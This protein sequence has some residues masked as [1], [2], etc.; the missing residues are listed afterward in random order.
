[1]PPINVLNFLISN[2]WFR[3]SSLSQVS[4]RCRLP[5]WDQTRNFKRY[6][7]ISLVP[8]EIIMVIIPIFFPC[9]KEFHD[10]LQ[11]LCK[12]EATRSGSPTPL[13][14]DFVTTSTPEQGD[15]GPTILIPPPHR[16]DDELHGPYPL[17][18]IIL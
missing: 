7:Q 6:T 2:L 15:S 14:V 17:H 16:Q 10:F 5:Y 3:K 13:P 12:Y 18:V 4:L 8:Y 11:A 9:L 1:M